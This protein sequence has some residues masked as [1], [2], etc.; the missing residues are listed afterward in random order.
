MFLVVAEPS[1]PPRY[2][3]IRKFILKVSDT[4][5]LLFSSQEV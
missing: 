2:R 4:K 1:G 3:E 5:Y